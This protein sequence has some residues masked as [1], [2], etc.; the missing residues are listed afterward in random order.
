[1]IS[2]TIGYT[3]VH[4]IFRHTQKVPG[5]PQKDEASTTTWSSD[6]T[7]N[8]PAI[9]PWHYGSAQHNGEHENNCLMGAH[10]L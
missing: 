7:I 9:Y 8:P 10:R 1:M 5:P 4:D 6:F 2:K 3:G